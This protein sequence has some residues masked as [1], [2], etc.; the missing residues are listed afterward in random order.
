MHVC[1]LTSVMSDSVILWTVARQARLSMGF[2]RQ[3]YWSGLPFPSPGDF[4]NPGMELCLLSLLH[5]QVGSL[6]LVPPGKP[7]SIL[8]SVQF[9]RS[10]MSNSLWP[11]GLQHAR[12]PC[13]S[14]TS[15]VYSNSCPLS[16]WCHPTISSCLPFS[17][18]LQSFP[19]PRSLTMSQLFASGGQ[20]IGV[21]ASIS[22]FQ[23]APRTDF[24]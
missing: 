1:I 10:V 4:P 11:H 14:P 2:S 9:S 18:R 17:S 16:W 6:P 23:W 3:E 20:S 19:A 12:P 13:P 22:S 15:R 5:W 24:L 21:S 8:S 7:Q